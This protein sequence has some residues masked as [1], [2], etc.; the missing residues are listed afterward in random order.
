MSRR[1][2]QRKSRKRLTYGV[3]AAIF[4][5]A[6]FLA[7]VSLHQ[8][9]QTPPDQTSQPKA[10][11]IDH[12]SFKEETKNETFVDASRRILEEA[13][14]YVKY[15]PG[16]IITVDF[17]KNLA[18]QNYSLIVLR[19]HSAIIG[20]GTEL[21]LFT[22]EIFDKSKYNSTSAPYFW[23]VYHKRL[24][25]AYFSEQDPIH[26]FAIAPGFVEEYAT[27][28][29]AIVIMMGCDGLKHNTTAEAFINKGAKVCIGWDG[30]VS[31]PHTDHATTCL[32][33]HL[34]QGKTIE[35]A[36]NETMN[37]VGPDQEYNSSLKYHPPFAGSYT[38]QHT[39]GISN[40][41]TVKANIILAKEEKKGTR[42]GCNKLVCDDGNL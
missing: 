4:I 6:C 15:Y 5:L 16:E 37:E 36:V 23:D 27:F 22:S 14:F 8:S 30:L 18:W 41:D 12:L 26:Y 42:T 38:I 10:A 13:G 34:A 2:K 39:L 7:Y 29:N 31:A 21:G 40:L 11:I 35:I 20:N 1:R 24:V 28:K 3:I 33:Q 19:A 25:E 9:N 17:Y 32:L